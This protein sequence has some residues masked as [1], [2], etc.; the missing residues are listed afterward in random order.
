MIDPALYPQTHFIRRAPLWTMYMYTNL[1]TACLAVLWL[2]KVSALGILFPLFIA[3]LVPVRLLAG[4]WLRPEDLAALDSEHSGKY[5][6]TYRNMT[7]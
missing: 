7:I 5:W 1:Q 2:V 6:L 3:L 4:R